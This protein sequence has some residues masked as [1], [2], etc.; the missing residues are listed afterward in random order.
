VDPLDELPLRPDQLVRL[1]RERF[2][3]EDPSFKEKAWRILCG[4]VFQRYVRDT[5]TVVDLGAGRCEFIN[6][7]RCGTKI[8]VDLNPDVKK[9]ARDSGVV[10]APSTD[11][12]DIPSGSVD[13]VF[14]SNFLEHLPTKTQVLNTLLEC[15]RILKS[16]GTLIILMPNMRY[17]SGR[18][19][20]FFDHHTP[21]THHSLAEA[22]GLASFR[23]RRM[24]PRFLPYSVRQT[25]FPKSHLLLW[26]YLRMPLVWPILGRQMLLIASSA[27][28]EGFDQSKGPPTPHEG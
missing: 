11:L 22:L 21:L 3:D 19:W 24:I 4:H 23:V 1:Y 12:G 15:H 25:R 26:I 16:G 9:Y 28:A 10:I 2:A 18:Y 6:A 20:D 27:E 8:A 7:I 13:V 5:D 17:L 14:S